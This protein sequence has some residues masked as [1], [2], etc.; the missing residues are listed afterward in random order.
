MNFTSISSIVL[1]EEAK[2]L[3]LTVEV[4]STKDNL[5]YIKSN[6]KEILF[7]STEFWMNQALGVKISHNKELADSILMRHWIPTAATWYIEKDELKDLQIHNFNFPLIIK[8][9]KESH[10]DGVMMNILSLEELQQKLLISFEKY[11]RMIIQTQVVWEEYRLLVMMWKV[12]LAINRVPA[13]VLWDG[14]KN[15]SELISHENN[16]NSLRGKWYSNALTNILIDNELLSY[17]RKQWLTLESIPESGITLQLRGT[18]NI[19]T[20]GTMIDVS[21]LVSEDIKKIAIKSA[22]IFWLWIAWI[23]IITT[24]ITKNLEEM[25]G[26]VLEINDSPWLWWDRELTWVNTAKVILEMLFFD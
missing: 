22:D 4:M 17:I 13:W 26:I 1:S 6:T 24:D 19:W 10:G 20:W 14:V 9:L 8:P 18:S 11:K 15:V 21:D 25:G 16:S 23:D 3:W 12:I 5:F 7:K 2:K